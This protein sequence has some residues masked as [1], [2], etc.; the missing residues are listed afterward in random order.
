MD[1]TAGPVYARLGCEQPLIRRVLPNGTL[2]KAA[3]FRRR[4]CCSVECRK[5]VQQAG[6]GGRSPRWATPPRLAAWDDAGA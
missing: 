1:A 2:E 3:D 5:I 6:L 4:T